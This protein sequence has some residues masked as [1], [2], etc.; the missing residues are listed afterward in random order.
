MQ[1]RYSFSL[2]EVMIACILTTAIVIFVLQQLKA[3]ALLKNE[4]KTMQSTALLQDR[5]VNKITHYFSHLTALPGSI[6]T[7]TCHD[8]T[9][10]VFR[11]DHG[12][13]PEQA[14][15]YEIMGKI[16][17]QDNLVYLSIFPKQDNI[18][19]PSHEKLDCLAK[20]VER[21]SFTFFKYREKQHAFEQTI[22]WD[23]TEP[24]LP[25]VM[26]LHFHSIGSSKIITHTFY[27]PTHHQIIHRI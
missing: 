7:M 9:A 25:D 23:M 3:S 27:L 2:L 16:F 14:L 18:L 24:S 13:N 19:S 12:V 4:L 20:D 15:C 1:K 21:I 6:Y 26:Q 8:H 5:M 10:L 11:F 22:T 17:L